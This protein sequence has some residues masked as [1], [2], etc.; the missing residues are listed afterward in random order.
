MLLGVP[1]RGHTAPWLRQRTILRARVS[2]MNWPPAPGWIR[3][4]SASRIW[5]SGRLRDVLEE[6][7][8][9]FD[10]GAVPTGEREKKNVGV[11]LACGTEKGSYVAAC[12]E[13][14]IDRDRKQIV[15]APRLRGVRVRCDPQSG[16]PARAGRGRHPHGTGAGLAR[17]DAVENGRM[18]N[19]SFGEY[20][21]PRLRDVPELDIH[22]LNRPDLASAGGGETPIIA[23][24]PAIANAV[25]QAT[26]RR[27]R[28]MPIR[29]PV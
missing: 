13:V 28:A 1:S 6:A 5:E 12:V 11:G 24:A 29:L 10:W 4:S 20:E 19:A 3:W 16:Q 17:G 15:P 21:V 9:R 2:W 22:L 23:V 25:F 18:L 7:A 26:G 27:V 8:R 14:E